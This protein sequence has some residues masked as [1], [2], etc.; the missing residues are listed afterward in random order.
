MVANTE[1][2]VKP[3]R[4]VVIADCDFI[5]KPLGGVVSLLNN[6]LSVQGDGLVEFSLVGISFDSREAEGVWQYKTIQR[7]MYR[8]MPVYVSPKA[9][10]DTRFPLRFR[11]VLGVKRYLR[12][13]GLEEF[14]ASGN[15]VSDTSAEAEQGGS[16]GNPIVW[17]IIGGIVV[18]AIAGGCVWYFCFF[19][20]GKNPFQKK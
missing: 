19:R 20:K 7:Q 17:W 2:L 8:W 3:L 13:I 4:A 9:K 12:V 10:D 14:D 18:A 15:K 1:S 5:D 16:T 6:M 11:L